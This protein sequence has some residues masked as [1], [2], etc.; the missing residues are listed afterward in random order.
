MK[1][2]KPHKKSHGK[3]GTVTRG[4]RE[5]RKSVLE[6]RQAAFSPDP[7]SSGATRRPGSTNPSKSWPR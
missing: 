5:R 2:R 1:Q 4:G 3:K 6:A 7:R